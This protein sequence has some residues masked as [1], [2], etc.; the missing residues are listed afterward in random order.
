MHHGVRIK[1]NALIAAAKLSQRYITDRFLPDKAIDLIDEAAAMRMEIDSAPHELNLLEHKIM[2]NKI[3]KEALKSDE[4]EN[5]ERFEAI[6]AELQEDE[7]KALKLREQWEY[8]KSQIVNVNELKEQ[9]DKTKLAI[10]E[11]ERK[12]DLQAA[13]LKYGTLIDEKK[14][15]NADQKSESNKS[16]NQLLKEEIDDNEI[17]DIVSKWTEFL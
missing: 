14:L 12:A 16:E 13:E 5:K 17:A 7:A 10:E 8:E 4:A 6:E 1:D 2:Q 15:T 11:A 3:E 9:I